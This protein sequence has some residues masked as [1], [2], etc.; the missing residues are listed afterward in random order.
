MKYIKISTTG[1]GKEQPS[2]PTSSSPLHAYVISISF[3]RIFCSQFI[4]MWLGLFVQDVNK[5]WTS[6]DFFCGG[7]GQTT[8]KHWYKFGQTSNLSEKKMNT[9][10][11][12]KEVEASEASSRGIS[13]C[14]F[15]EDL[16]PTHL[17]LSINLYCGR[18]WVGT[19][20]SPVLWLGTICA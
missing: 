10:A 9:F 5:K 12:E 13:L 1:F 16:P 15:D 3:V 4:C 20:G 18:L 19:V 17:H 8:K 6:D 14:R 11:E 7:F 2:S